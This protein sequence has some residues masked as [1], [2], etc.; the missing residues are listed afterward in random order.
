MDFSL[1]EANIW[2]MA[3]Y[4]TQID[5]NEHGSTGIHTY[6]F[7]G[8]I[9]A[10]LRHSAHLLTL[11]GYR[12]PLTVEVSL[13]SILGVPW[14]TAPHGYLRSGPASE[15]DDDVTFSIT[16]STDEMCADSSDLT[17]AVLRSAFYAVNLAELVDTEA[18]LEGLRHQAYRYNYWR[19]PSSVG[20]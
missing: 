12:G 15:L 10:A 14:L 19:Q 17:R 4:G 6:H 3:F 8:Y 9:L 11:V 1:F 2:G 5:V 16:T 18:K 7:A 13:A 20:P